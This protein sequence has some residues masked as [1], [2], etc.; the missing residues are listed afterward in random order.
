[1]T[2]L[3]DALQNLNQSIDLYLKNKT[4][5]LLVTF[6]RR[7]ACAYNNKGLVLHGLGDF[8]AALEC[9]QKSLDLR[10]NDVTLSETQQDRLAVERSYC[11]ENLG[12]LYN[13]MSNY[14]LALHHLQEALNIRNS[15]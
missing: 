12:L 10:Q 6:N 9:I 8:T 2:R 4:S 5:Y 13:D 15:K 3:T 11:H 1:M 14:K 7:L